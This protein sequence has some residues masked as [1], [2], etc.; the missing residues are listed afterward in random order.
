MKVETLF[1]VT[2]GLPAVSKIAIVK[3]GKIVPAKAVA[4]TRL[5]DLPDPKYFDSIKEFV[6]ITDEESLA[7]LQETE[8][9]KVVYRDIEGN[10]GV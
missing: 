8:E 4:I 7:K 5:K 2:M 9:L 1:K 6:L 10:I 3:D